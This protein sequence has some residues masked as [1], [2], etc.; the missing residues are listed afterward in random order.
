MSETNFNNPPE[1]FTDLT[2]VLFQYLATNLQNKSIKNLPPNSPP[3][4][5]TNFT[6]SN[7]FLIK[8]NK[9]AKQIIHVL[10]VQAQYLDISEDRPKPLYMTTS[11]KGHTC[12]Q[13]W[14]T[15]KK[16]SITRRI[17]IYMCEYWFENIGKYILL[18]TL[19]Q[20]NVRNILKQQSSRYTILKIIEENVFRE[21]IGSNYSP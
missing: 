13:V 12:Y 6:Y 18:S 7:T 10:K 17:K 20:R 15:C 1:Y 2:Q 5:N 9:Y 8:S 11:I 19:I 16:K 14:N 3:K 4:F 21:A